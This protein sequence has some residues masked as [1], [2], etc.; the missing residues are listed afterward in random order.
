MNPPIT[1]AAGQALR[2]GWVM[3]RSGSPSTITVAK[4]IATTSAPR[5]ACALSTP[6]CAFGIA[7][8]ANRTATRRAD[9]HQPVGKR[10][11]DQQARH[12]EPHHAEA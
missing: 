7:A 2:N 5:G 10:R 9:A 11:R 1:A 12:E 3:A 8:S 6:R 4:W